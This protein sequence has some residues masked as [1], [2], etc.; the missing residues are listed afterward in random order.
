MVAMIEI[1]CMTAVETTICNAN[2]DHAPIAEMAATAKEV[3]EPF[4]VAQT[5][6]FCQI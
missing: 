3:T 1:I 5:S 6:D 4:P 2:F